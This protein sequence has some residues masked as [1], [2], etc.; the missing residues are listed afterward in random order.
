MFNN[1]LDARAYLKDKE[2][3]AAV[4]IWTNTINR[5]QYIGSTLNALSR[6]TDYFQVSQLMSQIKNSNSAIC[7]AIIKYG[8]STFSLSILI[9]ENAEDALA[10]E[11][12]YLNTHILAYNINRTASGAAYK[13]SIVKNIKILIYNSEKTILLV[14]YK[15]MNAF[16]KISKLNSIQVRTL[17]NSDDKLWR[18]V[19]FVSSVL[20]ENADNTMLNISPFSP[21][22]STGS[23]ITYP[24]FVY[25]KGVKEPLY[26]ESQAKCALALNTYPKAIKFAIIN[27]SLVKGYRISRK[28]LIN[29]FN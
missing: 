9:L 26:F 4:Y 10:L 22:E 3:V 15:S 18:G 27:D 23:K 19:Y 6:L 24:V 28:P 16:I 17:I 21:I 20:L 7:R 1:P 5:K 12:L 25:K 14:I 8:Y 29:P 2:Y 11:Q 13:P